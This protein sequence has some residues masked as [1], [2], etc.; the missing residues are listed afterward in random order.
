MIRF[1][2]T[3][4]AVVL[5]AATAMA[6]ALLAGPARADE[7]AC[8]RYLADMRFSLVAADAAEAC[9]RAVLPPG[10]ARM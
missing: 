3:M 6:S 9:G 8:G 1:R 10:F 2:W 7:A 5:G 4:A